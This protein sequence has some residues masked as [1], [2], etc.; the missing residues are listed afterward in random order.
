MNDS[1]P[2]WINNLHSFGELAIVH[3]GANSQI[4]GKLKD[5]GLITM[6]VGYPPHHSGEVCQFLKL[7]TN[8][9]IASRTAIFINKTYQ[10]YFNLSATDVSR[11]VNPELDLDDIIEEPFENLVDDI[12]DPDIIDYPEVIAIDD[13]QA[14]QPI[15]QR[16]IRELRNLTTYYNPDPFQYVHAATLTT[17]NKLFDVCLQA[18][19]YDGNPD[20][21]TFN[22]AKQSPDWPNWWEAMCTEFKNMHE[23]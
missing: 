6:F 18:T 9:L 21:K 22:E 17:F 14:P 23:K 13:D 11:L 7:D 5:K 19:V 8:T 2:S 10:E 15:Q 16:G 12:Q 3:D 1:D 4:S 20:P